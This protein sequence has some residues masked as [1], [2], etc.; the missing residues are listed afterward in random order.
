MTSQPEPSPGEGR[1]A[2]QILRPVRDLAAYALVA[3]SAVLL[4]VAVIRLIPGGVGE[5]FA[6]RTQ[7]SFFNFVNVPVIAFPLGAVLLS[8]LIKPEHPKAKLIVL[9]A[10]VEYAAAA[11]FG[12]IFGILIGLVQIATFSVRTAFE[13]LLVR[14]SWLAVF[15]VAAFAVYQLWRNLF[16]TPKPKAQPG[17]YG[18]PQYGQSQYGQPEYGQS[19]YGQPEYGQPQYGQPQYG[20]PQYGQPQHG[21]SQHGQPEYAQPEYGQPQHGQPEYGQP[22]Q[23]GAAGQWGQPPGFFQPGP[24]PGGY[25]QPA[26]Q[27]VWGAPPQSAPP[28]QPAWG[29]PPQSA[30][31]A[32]SG[33]GE[34]P[35]GCPAWAPAAS[36]PPASAQPASAPPSY[37]PPPS[38]DFA[39]PTQAVPRYPTPPPTEADDRT[40]VVSDERPG[41]GPADGSSSRH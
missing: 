15:A 5:Q 17:M 19:Q 32:P 4:L 2:V 10:T 22:G 13:E 41:F 38:G 8:V 12:V 29:A 35:G 24:Q 11:F 37:G 40:Q 14:L 21:Q 36:A 23:P 16:H 30:P 28:A 7:D 18:Q 31:P 39:E 33:W 27:P 20:Q 9:V 26:A 34:Q 6:S 25:G 1:S 3:T